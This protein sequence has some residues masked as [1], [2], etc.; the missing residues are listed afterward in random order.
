M[1]KDETVS[2]G[3]MACLFLSFMIGSSIINLPQPLVEAAGNG[4]WLSVI[5]S[6]GFGLILLACIFYLYRKNPNFTLIDYSK[7]VFGKWVTLC[8][9]IP[10]LLLL[11]LVVP[12]IVIDIGGFFTSTMMRETPAYVFH[13]LILLVASFTVRAGMEVMAR[14][15]VILLCY[16]I[17]FTAAVLILTFP[18]YEVGNLLPVFP[19]G[20]KPVVY[21]SYRTIGF[22]YG[23]I[24]LFSFLL[25][26]LHKEKGRLLTKYMFSALLVY[27]LLLIISII[28][29]IMVFGPLAGT[30]KF[31]IFQLARLINIREILTRIESFIGIA[32]IVGSYMK[33]TIMLFILKEVLAKLLKLEDDRMIIFPTAFISLLLTLTMFKGEAEVGEAVFVVFPLIV[34]VCAVLPL[35]LITLM[36]A[37]RGKKLKDK[38]DSC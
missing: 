33:T 12:Y 26:F 3:Q 20:I 27:S 19:E 23:E 16:V 29:T 4:A 32:L 17:I 22:P 18:Y 6:N 15:F 13:M 8:L 25:P 36:A 11:F 34:A 28:C 35:L 1:C 24:V 30:F 10:T 5:I 31:S 38:G 7:K 14:M 37:V 9:F 2:S 21:G